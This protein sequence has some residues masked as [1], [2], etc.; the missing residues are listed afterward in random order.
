MRISKGQC[1]L[2]VAAGIAVLIAIL[3]F[4][5]GSGQPRYHL[6]S[7]SSW[8]AEYGDGPQ[9]YKPSPEADHALR[10]MGSNAVPYVLRLLH[11]TNSRSYYTLAPKE[12]SRQRGLYPVL[13][14][15]PAS[16]SLGDQLKAWSVNLRSRFQR[17]TTPP[18]WDHWKAYLAFQA[19]GPDGKP[20]I[21]DL[22]RLAGAPGTNSSPSGTGEMAPISFWKDKNEIQVFVAQSSTYMPSG[23]PVFA[24][25]TPMFYSG[26]V[27]QPFLSDA[28]I[29]AWSLAA[30][31]AD[32][33]P[34]LIEMLTNSSPQVGVRAAV[35]LGLMGKAAEPA[36]PDLISML[37]YPDN[38]VRREFAEVRRESADALGWIGQ[39]PDLV[40]PALIGALADRGFEYSAIIALGTMG[41]PASNAVPVLLRL[42]SDITLDRTRDQYRIHHA[43]TALSRISSEAATNQVIPFLISGMRNAESP[44]SRNMTI[45]T[46]LQMTNQPDQVIPPLI[47]ALESTEPASR[48]SVIYGLGAFGPRAKAAVPKLVLFSRSSETNACRLATN[49]LD[50]IEP[51]WRSRH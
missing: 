7:I 36:V 39:R 50:R 15:K 18:S 13:R 10:Q 44:W 51:G 47:E 9:N 48:N 4:Q 41:E 29:A 1:F 45:N 46:L 34:P 11:S 38:N 24:A 23:R 6:R 22:I 42:V 43:A 8:L 37:S 3:I 20:A 21:P 31:G 12:G 19:L 30:I 16:A 40:V 17:V 5:V 26:F 2:L 32:S 49:A 28:E 14:A 35:A 25:P 27:P 33:V